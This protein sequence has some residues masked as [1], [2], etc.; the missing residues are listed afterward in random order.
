MASHRFS[1]C[2]LFIYRVLEDSVQGLIGFLM[3]F[4]RIFVVLIRLQCPTWSHKSLVNGLARLSGGINPFQCADQNLQRCTRVVLGKI[5]IAKCTCDC[6]CVC[7]SLCV[8]L[9]VCAPVFTLGM[10]V[11]DLG[12]SLDVEAVKMSA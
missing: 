8:R 11:R 1:R 7:V 4:R 10:S 5:L 9:L 2:V 12:G 6:V 3:G